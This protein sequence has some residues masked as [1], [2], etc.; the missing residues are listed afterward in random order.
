M[1]YLL[2]D[3]D[4]TLWD[5][6]GNANRT[7]CEMY[8][9]FGL[10]ALCHVDYET[11]HR[12]YCQINDLLWEAYRCGTLSKELLALRRFTLTLGAFGMDPEGVDTVRL[13]QR[14][15]DYY[16][17]RGTQQTGLMPGAREL[18]EWLYARRDRFRLAV[19][20]NGFAEAQRPKMRTAGID[21]YFDY[22]F[23][24]EELGYMKPDPRFFE[25]ALRQMGVAASQCL[26]IGDD[27]KV[28]I[29][30]ARAAGIAQVY[31][32]LKGIPL[33]AGCEKP[34]YEIR[35]LREMIDVV[36]C[37]LILP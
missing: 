22:S 17:L 18:L 36:I 15:S 34:T 29:V 2:F 32:N 12:R 25:A 7:Y 8:D 37:N 33:P 28:D 13:A 21:R 3:L 35:D 9:H 4:R 10:E 30:G 23:L 6:D 31:Y 1:L 20:T 24:S 27:Y 14:M 19:I 16:V 26:V 11:F 5:F